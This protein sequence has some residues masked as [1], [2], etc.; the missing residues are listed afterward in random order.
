MALFFM[1]TRE[2]H[3]EWN[4]DRDRSLRAVFVR[5]PKDHH[6]CCPRIYFVAIQLD[7]QIQAGLDM[8]SVKDGVKAVEEGMHLYR[9][10]S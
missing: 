9:Q 2:S 8:S 5:T 7:L 3:G 6:D 10:A 4:M 1:K